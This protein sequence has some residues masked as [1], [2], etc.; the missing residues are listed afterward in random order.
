MHPNVDVHVERI[1]QAEHASDRETFDLSLTNS[2]SRR[3]VAIPR[4]DFFWK[5]CST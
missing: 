4:F 3:G 2:I 1:K 5:V